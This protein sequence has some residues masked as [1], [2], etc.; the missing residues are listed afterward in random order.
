M[1]SNRLIYDECV[2]DTQSKMD[3]NQLNWVLDTGRYINEKNCVVDETIFGKAGNTINNNKYIDRVDLETKLWGI[4]NLDS[5]CKKPT[6]IDYKPQNNNTC[7][8]FNIQSNE[9]DNNE[10]IN[11]TCS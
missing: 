5:K 10:L 11:K 1:S 8:F 7:N 9:L 6:E 3:E 4:G 2:Q